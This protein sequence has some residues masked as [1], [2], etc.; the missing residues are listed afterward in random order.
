MKKG[1][2]CVDYI[3]RDKFNICKKGDELCQKKGK[4]ENI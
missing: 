4:Q 1:Y 2:W 3:K